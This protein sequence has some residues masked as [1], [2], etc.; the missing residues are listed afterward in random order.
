MVAF[1]AA[2]A[3]GALFVGVELISRR[4]TGQSAPVGSIVAEQLVPLYGWAILAPVLVALLNRFAMTRERM[5][6]SLAVHLAVGPVVAVAK[7]VASAP[8]AAVFIWGPRDVPFA[9]GLRW[10]LANRVI[11]NTVLYWMLVAVYHAIAG[12]ARAGFEALREKE[13]RRIPLRT[14]GRV[15]LVDL[16]A[17]DHVG[18]EGNYVLVHVGA[19]VHRV[20][21]T[22]SGFEARLPTSRFLRIHRSAL[23]NVDRIREVQPWFHGDYA[24]VLRDGTQLIS[25]RTYRDRIRGLIMAR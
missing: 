1:P 22:L 25:G 8:L 4:S 9:D 2:A 13:A 19:H 21:E 14:D 12:P 7:L 17:I 11:P 24:V 18:V 10:I 15:V 3:I 23:V 20:R 5:W 16:D 6:P